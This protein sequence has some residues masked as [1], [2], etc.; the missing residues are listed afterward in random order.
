M[1]SYVTSFG[2]S[3][4]RYRPECVDVLEAVLMVCWSFAVLL[5][6]ARNGDSVGDGYTIPQRSLLIWC[7]LQLDRYGAKKGHWAI[8]TGCT[9][10]IGREFALQLS[11]AGFKVLLISRNGESLKALQGQLSM[12]MSMRLDVSAESPLSE[13]PSRIHAIDFASADGQAYAS[14]KSSIDSLDAPIGVLVNNVG[15]SHSMPVPFAECPEDEMEGT[16]D[17]NARATMRI[18]RIVLPHLLKNGPAKKRWAGD[19]VSSWLNMPN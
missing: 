11:R 4:Q 9:A 12:Y 15:V 5:D 13:N 14:L 6:L 16:L 7:V 3:G 8:I 10:G 2:K 1:S 17:I 19:K 18:T